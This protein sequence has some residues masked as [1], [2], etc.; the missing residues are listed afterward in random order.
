MRESEPPYVGDMTSDT[1]PPARR[2]GPLVRLG[3]LAQL[4]VIAPLGVG[5]LAIGVVLLLL[6]RSKSDQ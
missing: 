2:H 4:A 6:L 3:A 1:P 5:V